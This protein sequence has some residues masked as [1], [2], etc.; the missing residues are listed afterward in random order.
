MLKILNLSFGYV[1]IVFHYF[2]KSGEL[3]DKIISELYLQK[4]V[5]RPIKFF[6]MCRRCHGQKFVIEKKLTN[7]VFRCKHLLN[8]VKL[9]S[10]AG[11]ATA[12]TQQLQYIK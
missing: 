11:G 12:K 3:R 2:W 4:Q 7:A 5:R 8:L 10:S 9:S 1:G 6:I